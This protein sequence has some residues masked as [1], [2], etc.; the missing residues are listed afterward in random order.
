MNVASLFDFDEIIRE[1]EKDRAEM[2]ARH[3][4]HKLKHDRRK[5]NSRDDHLR[6]A[7]WQQ[8]DDVAREAIDRG[9]FSVAEVL[10][11]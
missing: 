7:Y 6:K 8:L 4:L 3:Q 9:F 5:E 11:L 2:S 10:A 1:T